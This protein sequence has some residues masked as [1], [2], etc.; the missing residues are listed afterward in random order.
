[1]RVLVPRVLSSSW[2]VS[3]LARYRPGTRCSPR[4]CPPAS[5]AARAGGSGLPGVKLKPRAEMMANIVA[6]ACGGAKEAGEGRG[7]MRRSGYTHGHRPAAMDAV[8]G[9]GRLG[10]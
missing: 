10:R 4:F 7:T 5:R 2:S 9:V 1:M 6:A 3:W 8:V